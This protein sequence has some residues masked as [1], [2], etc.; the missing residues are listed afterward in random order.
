MS[1]L[2]FQQLRESVVAKNQSQESSQ[3]RMVFEKLVPAS[4]SAASRSDD[5]SARTGTRRDPPFG[6]QEVVIGRS[7][8]SLDERSGA[9]SS[10]AIYMCLWALYGLDSLLVFNRTANT[11]VGNTALVDRA[12][13]SGTSIWKLYL[14]RQTEG[15]RFVCPTEILRTTMVPLNY[16]ESFEEQ[17]GIVGRPE[18]N[19]GDSGLQPLCTVLRKFVE[20]HAPVTAGVLTAFNASYAIVRREEHYMLIDS[21]PKRGTTLYSAATP[22]QFYRMVLWVL[23][24]PR[25]VWGRELNP[26]TVQSVAAHKG[27]ALVSDSRHKRTP[28]DARNT[29]VDQYELC[30]LNPRSELGQPAFRVKQ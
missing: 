25:E 29:S 19:V 5:D 20:S 11:I 1:S 8:Y 15:H 21:H 4:T 28:S 17:F 10:I 27:R 6:V 12:V 26:S 22:E 7:Q 30:M 16:L 3:Q 18:G 14:E 2:N 24:I 9:C 23:D 13:S